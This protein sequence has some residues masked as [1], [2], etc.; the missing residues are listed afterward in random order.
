MTIDKGAINYKSEIIRKLV[1][2]CSLSI[3]V[4]YY[5]I[6]KSTALEILIPLTAAFLIA[7]LARY[8]F[9]AAARFFYLL[10]GFMLR[11]HEKDNSKK[12]LNGAT[13]VLISA[14]I[15]ILIFPKIF[16]VTGFAVLIISDSLAALL[17]RKF[18]KTP[19][20]CKSLEGT[21]A[22]FLSA[23]IVVLLT[24]KIEGLKIEYIF[25][26]IAVAVGAIIE[27][28][29]Y[30]WADDNLSIPISIG[31]VLWTLYHLFLPEIGLILDN[32]PI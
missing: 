16:V 14:V 25:G 7:D 5:Y 31:V 15:C 26:F 1:H 4:I 29:S 13:Y 10:F 3:P 18:G 17:G 23:C 6:P 12:N 27:N 11:D 28:I 19:F 32:V 20:L 24:P 8:F 9:S 21:L 22:F 2:L 30:G